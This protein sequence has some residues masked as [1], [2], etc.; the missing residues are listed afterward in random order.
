MSHNIDLL[1]RIGGNCFG[2]NRGVDNLIYKARVC[3]V[4]QQAPDQI[5]QQIAVFAN[6]RVNSA[7]CFVFFMHNVM[8]CLTHSV[9]TLKLEPVVIFLSHVQDGSDCVGIMRGELWVNA[10]CHSQ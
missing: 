9:K 5:G 4:F 6:R 1:K 3:T 10:I 7:G 8:Q 2:W